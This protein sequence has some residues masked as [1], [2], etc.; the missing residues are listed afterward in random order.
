M[1]IYYR[2]L[3]CGEKYCTTINFIKSKFSHFEHLTVNFGEFGRVF[4]P[5]PNEVYYSYFKKHIKGKVICSF[6]A[7]S[8]HPMLSFYVIK[9]NE[10]FQEIQDEIETNFID[11]IIN[12]YKEIKDFD[13]EQLYMF[14]EL[15]NGK[16][17][18]HYYRVK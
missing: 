1:K 3:N 4:N 8:L 12:R 2:N 11:L 6:S 14:V 15:L 10:F 16:L 7:T 18:M 17:I 9:E 13:Y 5:R